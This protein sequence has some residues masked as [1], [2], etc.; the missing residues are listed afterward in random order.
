MPGVCVRIVC[1][2]DKEG[3]LLRSDAVAETTEVVG[4]FFFWVGLVVAREDFEGLSGFESK[5]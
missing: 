2:L 4:V 1:D 3:L 5:I